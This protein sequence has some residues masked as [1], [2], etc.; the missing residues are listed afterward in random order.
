MPRFFPVLLTALL[1]PS[2]A[3]AAVFLLEDFENTSGEI[4]PYLE[5]THKL[6]PSRN[7]EAVPHIT[8]SSD[9]A[10]SGRH[11]LRFVTSPLFEPARTRE[12][13]E[14]SL[15][16]KRFGFGDVRCYAFSSYIADPVFPSKHGQF[17]IFQI[18]GTDYVEPDTNPVVGIRPR[19]DKNDILVYAHNKQDPDDVTSAGAVVRHRWDRWLVYLDP[20]I[21]DTGRVAIWRNG[22]RVLD[23]R[24]PNVFPHDDGG[25][26][27]KFGRY[28][29]KYKQEEHRRRYIEEGVTETATYFD[30]LVF[31]DGKDCLDDIRAVAP[32]YFTPAAAQ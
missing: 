6:K 32:A 8:L 28:N 14:L 18:H 26:Y 23:H 17:L 20:Q 13:T 30:D 12:R 3:C 16:K 19:P 21:D 11:S 15:R 29:W 10:L 24:G 4:V 7:P 1:L 5:K 31:A 9:V 2:A 25:L 27:V 22:V